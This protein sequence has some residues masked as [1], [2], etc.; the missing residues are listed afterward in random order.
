MESLINVIAF[1]TAKSGHEAKVEE[2][3][4]TAEQ[5][6]QSEPGCES[7]VLTKDITQE[8]RFIMLE[9]WRDLEAL[10]THK[11]AKAFVKLVAE[12]DGLAD[13]EVTVATPVA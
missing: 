3:L 5:E 13:L 9:V 12:I 11:Q 2:A 10:E 8:N 6:V 4:K 7:Y 1:I